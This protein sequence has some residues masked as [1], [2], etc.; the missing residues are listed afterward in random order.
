MQHHLTFTML[1][2]IYSRLIELKI[3]AGRQLQWCE[4]NLIEQF[5]EDKSFNAKMLH[6]LFQAQTAIIREKT[7]NTKHLEN[8]SVLF[9]LRSCVLVSLRPLRL[10]VHL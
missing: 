10:L 8:S 3:R 5:P 1:I 7:L 2:L 4:F 9:P 6:I